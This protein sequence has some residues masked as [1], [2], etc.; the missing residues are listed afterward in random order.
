MPESH[1]FRLG[2]GGGCDPACH[3]C[4]QDFVM[5]ADNSHLLAGYVPE[6]PAPPTPGE[7][8]W[9]LTKGD[10]RMDCELRTSVAGVEVQLIRDGEWF[11]GCRF[12]ER[13]DAVAHGEK[14]RR[15]LLGRG[16][17]AIERPKG[18]GTVADC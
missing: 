15:H 3:M 12:A 7:P 5:A 1:L 13:A 8:F 16:W 14:H 11:Y 6:P 4:A 17:Q 2:A 10:N 9:T 18:A